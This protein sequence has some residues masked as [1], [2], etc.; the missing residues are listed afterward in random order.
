[1]TVTSALY[2]AKYINLTECGFRK[3]VRAILFYL[4]ERD[5]DIGKRYIYIER[6]TEKNGLPHSII[7]IIEEYLIAQVHKHSSPDYKEYSSNNL[8]SNNFVDLIK[9]FEKNFISKKLSEMA[10]SLTKKNKNQVDIL[11]SLLPLL[12]TEAKNHLLNLKRIEIIHD[13]IKG[14]ELG[15]IDELTME[16]DEI[17]FKYL[18]KEKSAFLATKGKG[19]NIFKIDYLN[20]I[21]ILFFLKKIKNHKI[22]DFVGINNEFDFFVDPKNFDY[23]NFVPSWL[24]QYSGELLD[25]ISKNKHMKPQIIKILKERIE[26]TKDKKYLEILLNHFL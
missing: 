19:I 22:K 2:F 24:K 10:L 7:Q 23:K 12:S 4:P 17:I 18:E 8:F 21:A 13:L 9:H 6:L 14:I 25:E 5:L 3:I 15:L 16:H 20:I 1:M 11:F 26:K